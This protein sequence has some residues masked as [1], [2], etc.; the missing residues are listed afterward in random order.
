MNRQEAFRHLSGYW[1]EVGRAEKQPPLSGDRR[2]VVKVVNEN[3][4]TINKVLRGLGPDMRLIRA[5]KVSHHLAAWPLVARALEILRTWDEMAAARQAVGVPVLPMSLLDPVISEVAL[6]LW[7]A[8]K[9]RQAVNDAATNL[10]SYAQTRIGRHDISDKDLMGQALSE[11]EPEAG[12]A[13]LRCPGSP[14]SETVR[15]QQEGARAFAIGTFQAIR[16]PAHHLPGD[17]NP[18]TAFHHLTALSQVT[19]WFRH[20]D[21]VEYSPPPPDYSVIS[22]ALEQYVKAQTQAR[23][24][25]TPPRE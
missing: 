19:H 15:S 1:A 22:A 7:E 3:L 11:K 23:P 14:N 10:N 12:K 17:W 13:R 16:N 21:V 25:L 20:W 4:P 8:E 9:Y 24:A 6:P 2:V 18:V 5:S